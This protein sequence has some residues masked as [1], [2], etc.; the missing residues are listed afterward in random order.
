VAIQPPA[1]HSATCSSRFPAGYI[2]A[3][4]PGGYGVVLDDV[5]SGLYS[6]V[7]VRLLM[8]LGLVT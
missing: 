7:A 3:N 4:F 8:V 6:N 1:G 2:D 5:V